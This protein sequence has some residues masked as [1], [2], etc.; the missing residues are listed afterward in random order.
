VRLLERDRAFAQLDDAVAHGGRVVV[1][2]GEAGIGKTALVRRFAA[3]TDRQVLWGACDD[4]TVPEPLG[5]LRDVAEEAV[6]THDLRAIGRALLAADVVVLEDCHWA[7]EATL[8]VLAHVGRRIG[9]SGAVLVVTFRD[10]ELSLDHQLR[11]VVASIPRED[12]VRIP[13]EPLSCDAVAELGGDPELYD[14]TGGNPFLVTEAIAGSRATVR[15]AVLA[16]AARLA[17]AARRLLDLVSVVP[18][19]AELWLVGDDDAVSECERSGLLVVEGETVR[20]RHELARRAYRESLSALRRIDLNRTALRRLEERGEDPVRLV[21]HAEAAQDH[22]SLARHA[23]VAAQRAVAARSHREAVALFTRALAHADELAPADRAAAYEGL[24]REAYIDGRADLAVA[25]QLSALALRRTL[26]DERAVGADLRWLSRLHWWSG[27]RPEAEEAAA[28]AI[29]VLEPLGPS[30]ELAMAYSTQ[31][32]LLMLAQRT[33]AA[34]AAGERA[35]ALAEALADTET[36]VHALTNVGTARMVTDRD[37]G[38]E[39]LEQAVRLGLDRGVVEDTCRA[40]HNI[41]SVDYDQRRL[42]L[43]AGEIDAA[44][45]VARRLEHPWFELDTLVLRALYELAVGEWT[46]A[47]T[48]VEDVLERGEPPPVTAVPIARVLA[49]V[50]LRRG[51]P[52]AHALVEQAWELARPFGEL[53]W[54]RPAAALKAEAAWLAG[55]AA[56]VDAATRDAYAT[57]LELGHGWDRG[58]LAL[59]RRRAGLVD[60]SPVAGGTEQAAKSRATVQFLRALAAPGGV[61]EPYA[62][63]LAGDWEGAARAWERIGEPYERAL[64]LC[65]APEPDAALAG[66]RILDELGAAAPARLVRRRLTAQGVPG[67]PRGPR[68]STRANPAGLSARQ[69][70]VLALIGEGLSNPEIARRLFLTPKTVEHHVTAILRKLRV[71][72]R[73]E[74][75][76][77]VSGAR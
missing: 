40:A 11:S 44:L 24:S 38:A 66:L 67:V 5:P 50:E 77:H 19:R 53:Q 3:E 48:T 8:D 45:A 28:E 36:L 65:D 37:R 22:A 17:P 33:D 75:V 58:E 21:H 9:R 27:R 6:A 47:V 25:P 34:I 63:A 14:A 26:G 16:R 52:Q 73:A 57:A 32:Q 35:I 54:V 10:D 64:A 76:A 29:A 2:S 71:A 18:G 46:A 62:L 39:E 72:T 15:D 55:D 13:L 12:V 42:D 68:A 1:V 60:A 56:A 41:A 30:R 70:E 4:L 20:F 61:A 7:D 51:G 49:S 69:A 74:A 23:L 59:W 31:S 43:A